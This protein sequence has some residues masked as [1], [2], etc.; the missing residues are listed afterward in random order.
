[1]MNM[2]LKHVFVLSISFCVVVYFID[3]Q[4]S[5]APK[6]SSASD[7]PS[8]SQKSQSSDNRVAGENLDNIKPQNA[9]RN[10]HQPE[11][12]QIPVT[13]HNSPDLNP[14]AQ[15]TQEGVIPQSGSMTLSGSTSAPNIHVVMVLKDAAKNPNLQ[16]K[17]DITIT[18]IF[19]HS[20]YVVFIFD[21]VI[22]CLR[23]N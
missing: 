13:S 12:K 18:S 7:S 20:R 2:K 8:N 17:F 3:Q 19:K 22:F 1:M 4:Y 14:N 10:S 15:K 6:S 21:N 23:R 11:E 5:I 16:R 9:S